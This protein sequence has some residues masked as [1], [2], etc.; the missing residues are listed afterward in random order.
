MVVS[1]IKDVTYEKVIDL[2]MVARERNETPFSNS[3]SIL[4]SILLSIS[5][6]LIEKGWSEAWN[7]EANIYY[8]VNNKA[9]PLI[10]PF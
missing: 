3:P 10:L 1:I 7:I 9:N 8:Q 6:T 5:S 4:A 2:F